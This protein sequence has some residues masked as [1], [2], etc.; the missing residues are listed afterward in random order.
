MAG[1]TSVVFSLSGDF[2]ERPSQMVYTPIQVQVITQ[3]H[4]HPHLH[5]HQTS[6]TTLHTGPCSIS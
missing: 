1:L 6:L 2:W 3:R 5:T 4:R